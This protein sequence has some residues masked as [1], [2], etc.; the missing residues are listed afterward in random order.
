M[1][2]LEPEEGFICVPFYGLIVLFRDNGSFFYE[3][4]Q[5]HNKPLG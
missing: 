4:F 2:T 5:A 1:L 3:D